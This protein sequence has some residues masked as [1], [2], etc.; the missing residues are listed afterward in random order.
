MPKRLRFEKIA[1]FNLNDSI[2][3]GTERPFPPGKVRAI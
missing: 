2:A 3:T 1:P